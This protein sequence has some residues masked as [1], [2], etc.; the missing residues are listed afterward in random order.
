MDEIGLKTGF[1]SYIARLTRWRWAVSVA[2]CVL[3]IVLGFALADLKFTSDYRVYFGPTNPQLQAYN[4]FEQVYTSN[5]TIIIVVH[6]TRGDIFRSEVLG[7]LE[8]LTERAW[9]I[10]Y[11]VRVD[12]LTNFQH[13]HVDGDDLFVGS[14]VEGAASLDDK[15]LATIRE[16][17]LHEPILVNRL[18]SVDGR[19]A[20]IAVT[21]L[22]P[23]TDHAVHLPE[24]VKAAEAL[25]NEAN[26]KHPNMK[27]VFTG[28]PRLSQ[29]LID[30]SVDELTRMAPIMFVL[31][32]LMMG[33]LLRTWSGV[34][35]T[36]VV[37]LA[38]SVIA[39]AYVVFADIALTPGTAIAP[40]VVL[41][42][43]VADCVHIVMSMYDNMQEG[44]TREAAVVESLRVNAQPVF[45][46]S[47]TTTIGFL[48]LNFSDSPPFQQLGNITAVGV[49]AAWLLSMTLLPSLLLIFPIKVPARSQQNVKLMTRF[50]D[51]V[52]MHR[53]IILWVT[54]VLTL[55]FMA[56][57]PLNSIND[58]FV[59]WFDESIPARGDTDFIQ[60]NLTGTYQMEFSIKAGEAGSVTAPRYLTDLDRFS[61]WLRS[62]PETQHVYSLADVM[63]GL[64]KSMHS[65]DPREYVLP[66][67]ADMAAQYL[68]LYELSLQI[69]RAHV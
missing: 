66:R 28:W 18:V 7:V 10:P 36:M 4:A 50:G 68:L 40:I 48:S 51:F 61:T 15:A 14:L 57:T 63:K 35:S 1:N 49:V 24:A 43:A 55:F 41:T 29:V 30:I 8:E 52:V 47:L 59:T 67:Q 37:V 58:D 46:T 13:T 26:A 65:D 3:V 60:E 31:L 33:L 11:S 5:D 64:N 23:G 34:A 56:L 21:L 9:Q 27:I 20:G 6:T 39:M 22:F 19:T 12:S 16:I 45:L 25:V 2:T 62:Q 38:A 17:A 44:R 53:S 42:I 32:V 54:L 69:G